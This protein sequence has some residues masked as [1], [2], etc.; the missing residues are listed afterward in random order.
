MHYSVAVVSKPHQ[1]LD[2]S[3]KQLRLGIGDTYTWHVVDGKNVLSMH[4]NLL[5]SAAARL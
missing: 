4:R 3:M 2:W 5:I 1:V